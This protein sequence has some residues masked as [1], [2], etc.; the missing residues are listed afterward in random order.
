[1]NRWIGAIH[2]KQG[3]E[4]AAPKI[5]VTHAATPQQQGGI[6]CGVYVIARMMTLYLKNDASV[7]KQRQISRIR[8]HLMV[9]MLA[10]SRGLQH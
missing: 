6:D 1:M 9:T 4:G 2:K 7:I 5:S 8:D 3:R 10:D